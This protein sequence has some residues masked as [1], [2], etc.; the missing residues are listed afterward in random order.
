MEEK[1]AD[2]LARKGWTIAEVATRWEITPRRVRQMFE[3]N[4]RRQRDT[5]NGL[6]GKAETKIREL[7]KQAL[8]DDDYDRNQ[9]IGYP[10]KEET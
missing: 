7:A 3:E 9:T 5:F 4:T 8:K 2:I 10:T 6:P 1:F